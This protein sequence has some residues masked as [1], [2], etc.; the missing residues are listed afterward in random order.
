MHFGTSPNSFVISTIQSRR[1][2]T[3]NKLIDGQFKYYV[4][5]LLHNQF[6]FSSNDG[7]ISRDTKIFLTITEHLK[8]KS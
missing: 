2:I 7:I 6:Y 5:R 8:V 4:L 3:F 1:L